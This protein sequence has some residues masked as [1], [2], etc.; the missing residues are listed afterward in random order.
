MLRRVIQRGLAGWSCGQ[1]YS[2]PSL[3]SSACGSRGVHVT[4]GPNESVE[5][6]YRRLKRIMGKEGYMQKMREQR[7]RVKPCEKRRE[8]AKKSAARLSNR[9]FKYKLQWILQRQKRGY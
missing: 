2:F 4:V 9:R 7:Y 5:R 6:A 1:S 3:Q 8:E